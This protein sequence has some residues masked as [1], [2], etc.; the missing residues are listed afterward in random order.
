MRRKRWRRLP[1]LYLLGWVST[2]TKSTITL[3]P[4]RMSAMK[5]SAAVSYLHSHKR[6]EFNHK[7]THCCY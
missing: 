3:L 5:M 2:L 7:H 4:V 6:Y 1:L